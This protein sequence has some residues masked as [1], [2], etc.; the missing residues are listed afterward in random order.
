M[1][2][3]W[4]GPGTP[5][6]ADAGN[7]STL[8]GRSLPRQVRLRSRTAA[9]SVRRTLISASPGASATANGGLDGAARQGVGVAESRPARIRHQDVEFDHRLR[10]S[11]SARAAAS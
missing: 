9:A 2:P 8:V 6:G 1:S 11:L 3:R 4:R 7:D 10:A 5:G